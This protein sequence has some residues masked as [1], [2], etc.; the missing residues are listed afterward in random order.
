[1]L[2]KPVSQSAVD[3]LTTRS[4][5][6]HA[7]CPYTV[8]PERLNGISRILVP[9]AANIALAIAGATARIGGSPKPVGELSLCI[10]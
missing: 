10:K 7:S 1:M 5:L 4:T 6:V 3:L 8:I 9:V 2:S